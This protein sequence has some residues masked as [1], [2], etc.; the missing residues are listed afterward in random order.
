MA[1]TAT[2]ITMAAGGIIMDASGV[3]VVIKIINRVKIR[4]KTKAKDRQPTSTS[5]VTI[6]TSQ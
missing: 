2:A 1:A 6:T 4:H 3:V 5:K